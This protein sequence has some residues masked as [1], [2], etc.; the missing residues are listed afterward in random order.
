M[1]LA[2]ISS[3]ASASVWSGVMVIGLTTMPLSKRLTWR[4]AVAC[5]ST[6]RL[7]W[8]TPIPPSW[9]SAIAMS[10]SVTVSIADD[11]IGMLSGI[12]RVRKVRVSAWLGSTEDSSGCS[13]TS[14]NVSPSGMSEASLSWAISAHDRRSAIRQGAARRAPAPAPAAPLRRA[15]ARSSRCRTA[16]RRRG[17][18][19][20]AL[21]PARSRPR[22]ARRRGGRARS[23]WDGSGS[24]RRSR[25]AARPRASARKPSASSSPLNTPSNAAMPAARAASTIICSEA[26]IGSRVASSGSRRSARRSLVPA[27][28]P[29]R[30]ACAISG[31]ASTPAAVSIIASTGLPTAS[32]D[33]ADEMRRDGA[34]NDDQVGL[35]SRDRIEIERMPF[36]PDAVDPDRDRHRPAPTRPPRPPRSRAAALS[37]GFTASSRSRTTRSAPASR[38]LA[39]ARGFDAGRNSIDRTANRSTPCRFSLP[40][41]VIAVASCPGTGRPGKR[42]ADDFHGRRCGPCAAVRDDGREDRPPGLSLHDRAF[43]ALRSRRRARLQLRDRRSSTASAARST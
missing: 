12:S 35:R 22:S 40:L 9:A 25:A 20:P 38:A 10:A 32:R 28:R 27:I 36:G 14:S 4:T 16:R 5:S 39:I 1:R 29:A 33:V 8:S 30:L 26:E 41:R 34:R 31:A 21:A 43:R 19:R 2:F 13:R 3:S 11:R 15:C 37:S 42:N 17:R 24:C 7:R 18:H 23:G 6:L